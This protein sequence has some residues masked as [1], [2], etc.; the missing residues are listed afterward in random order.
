ME[1]GKMSP[2]L[3]AVSAHSHVNDKGDMTLLGVM[4]HLQALMGQMRK[5]RHPLQGWKCPFV[6]T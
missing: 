1:L 5:D 4:T 3:T 2:L 6:L